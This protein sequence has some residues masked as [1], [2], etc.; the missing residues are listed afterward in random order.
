MKFEYLQ[1]VISEVLGLGKE[2]ITLEADLVAD[3]GADSLDAAELVMAIE[4]RFK[5]NISDEEAQKFKSVNEIWN[6]IDGYVE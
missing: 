4:D 5:V 3:L 2:D 1:E 6:F